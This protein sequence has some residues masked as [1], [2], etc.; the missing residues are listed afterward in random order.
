MNISYISFD[1]L[2]ITVAVIGIAMAF[3]VLAWNAVKAIHD[4]RQLARRPTS[5][6]LAD[7]GQRIHVLEEHMHVVDDKLAGDWEFR[8]Q[9][10]EINNLMLRSIKHLLQHEVDGNNVKALEAMEAEI[11]DWLFD[12]AK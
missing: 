12:H 5:D 3:V 11:D 10:R 7:H 4:W 6:V 9:E 1:E 8:Q 2:G